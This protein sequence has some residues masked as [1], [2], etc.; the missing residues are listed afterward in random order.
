ME[1]EAIKGGRW[2]NFA[3]ITRLLAV[4]R[5]HDSEGYEKRQQVI[6]EIKLAE[7]AKESQER[8]DYGFKNEF[9][10]FLKNES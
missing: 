3:S 10:E 8:G 4:L 9:G 6:T 5:R 7:L 1:W 2:Q